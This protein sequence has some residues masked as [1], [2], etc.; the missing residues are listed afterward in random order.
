MR[1][2]H[3]IGGL[4]GDDDVSSAKSSLFCSSVTRWGRGLVPALDNRRCTELDEESASTALL[5]VSSLL[6]SAVTRWRQL[7]PAL[8]NLRTESEKVRLPLRSFLKPPTA[9][10]WTAI[11]ILRL[12][13]WGLRRGRN[14][15]L[16]RIAG[17]GVLWDLDL[18][19]GG[20]LCLFRPWLFDF[21]QSAKK[22]QAKCEVCVLRRSRNLFRIVGLVVCFVRFWS[23]FLTFP[24]AQKNCKHNVSNEDLIHPDYSQPTLPSTIF[25]NHTPRSWLDEKTVLLHGPTKNGNID[26][27]LGWR[28]SPSELHLLP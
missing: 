12:L 24:R 26:H 15:N 19:C 11:I 10:R 4:S 28:K 23:D 17:F 22:L 3:L 5:L 16:V 13:L 18:G 6:P 27:S 8:D 20:M 2:D 9:R 14:L 25:F 7:V 1:T 21:S